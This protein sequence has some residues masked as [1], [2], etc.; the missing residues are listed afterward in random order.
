MRCLLRTLS[1]HGKSGVVV[2]DNPFEGDNLSIGRAVDQT[3][4]L[5][6]ARV[7]LH[8]A[9]ISPLSPG[10]FLLQSKSLAGIRVN[11]RLS[12]SAVIQAGDII[13]IGNSTLRVLE[14]PEAYE[15]AL[16]VERNAAQTRP[17]PALE[18]PLPALTLAASGLHVRR[19]AWAGFILILILFLLIPAGSRYLGDYYYPLMDELML[20]I[21]GEEFY[22]YPPMPTAISDRFW[23]SGPLASAHHFFRQDCASCHQE[24]FER[25]PDRACV[26][27]HKRTH[28]HV[29]PVFFDLDKLQNTRCAECHVEH[30]GKRA[31]ILRDD[32]LCSDCH[33]DLS[34][35]GVT[36]ELEDAYDFGLQHPPFKV[37]LLGHDNGMEL[38][39]RVSMDDP[40]RYRER[41]NLEFSHSVHLSKEGLSTLDGIFRLWCDDCHT[42]TAGNRGMEAINYEQHCERCH[43]LSF[44]ASEQ[45]R[46]VPHGRVNEVLYTLQEYYST[47]AL[48]GGYFGEGEIPDV[49]SRKRDAGVDLSAEERAEALDWARQKAKEVSQELFEFSVCIECHHSTV[50]L[51]DPPLW[52]IKPVRITEHWMPRA[53]FTHDKHLTMRCLF[54]HAAP[55]SAKSSDILLPDIESCRQCHGG[56]HA[57]DKLQSTCVDCHGFHV[58]TEFSMGK[59]EEAE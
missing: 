31:L 6:D 3:L 55:E 19:W 17:R 36:T 15:L 7:A 40:D 2:H 56:V 16:E 46:V 22:D 12:Q 45:D 33:K 43:P 28:P 8:H 14:P 5:A 24:A 35:Q 48:E 37:R 25:V 11:G 47:R 39:D 4:F 42:H 38:N 27:C 10:R 26:N 23:N 13:R 49:V 1:R 18:K 52:D 44:E 29:D 54:C 30:N 41:S 34:L 57:D 50:T 51:D 21:T 58:A 32:A 53:K 20:H 59:T 9:L